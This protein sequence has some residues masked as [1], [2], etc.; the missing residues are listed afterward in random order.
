MTGRQTDRQTDRQERQDRQD[1][2][3]RHVVIGQ[4]QQQQRMQ[5]LCSVVKVTERKTP[6]EAG[7]KTNIAYVSCKLSSYLCTAVTF[8][9][10]QQQ[11]IKNMA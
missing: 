3:D 2:Q 5:H 1:R 11:S 10:I 6:Q 4:R 7:G 9:A 8:S